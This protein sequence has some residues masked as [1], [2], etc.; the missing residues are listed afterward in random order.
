[1]IERRQPLSRFGKS[2]NVPMSPYE[3]HVHSIFQPSLRPLFCLASN[4]L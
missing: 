1:M 3:K 4:E 2:C